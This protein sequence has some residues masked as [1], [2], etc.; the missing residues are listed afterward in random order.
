MGS[1]G[2]I[3]SKRIHRADDMLNVEKYALRA[4]DASPG[5]FRWRQFST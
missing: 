1:P 3:Y 5:K 2:V 4:Y